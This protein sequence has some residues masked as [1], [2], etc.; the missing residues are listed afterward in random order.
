[1]PKNVEPDDRSPVQR[2]GLDL[3]KPA[4]HI[5]ATAIWVRAHA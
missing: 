3:S 1:M 5:A 2:H 4:H